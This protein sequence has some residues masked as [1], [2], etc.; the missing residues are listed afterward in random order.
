MDAPLLINI[1][2]ILIIF[3][4]GAIIVYLRFKDK[5]VVEKLDEF[6]E[7]KFELP[8]IIT[9]IKDTINEITNSNLYDLGLNEEEFKR[10]ANKRSKLKHALKESAHGD[11]RQKKYVKSYLYDLLL[12]D[13]G[14]N[15]E[16]INLT[17]PFDDTNRLTSQDKFDILIKKVQKKHKYNALNYLIEKHDLARLKNIIEGGETHS[18]IIT[19]EEIDNVY[20]KEV[21][22][23][24]FEDKL[25][26]IVQRVYQQYKGFGVIDE[27]RDMNI[28]GV[29]GG[30]NGLPSSSVLFGE[31]GDIYTEQMAGVTMPYD[32]DSVWIFYKGKSI[33]LSFLSFGSEL[34]LKRVCHNIYKYNMPG[35]LTENNGFKV[36]EMKDGSRVVVV[37]PSFAESYAFFV[38][39]FDIPNAN[40]DSL[41]PE[42]KVGN[43]AM[44]KLA[45]IF[46]M[47]G[48]RVTAITGA[49]GSGKTT[50]MMAMVKHISATLNVRVQEMAF[51]LHLRKIFPWRNILSF[52]ETETVTGQQGLDL[53][54]KVDGSVTL[55]GEMAEMKTAS[56]VIQ[57][58]EVA[59]DFTMFTGH[60]NTPTALVNYMSNALVK[61]DGFSNDKAEE[62]VVNVLDFNIHLR[63]KQNG[64]RH[65]ERITEVIPLTEKKEYPELNLENESFPGMFKEF[66]TTFRDFAARTTDRK[67]Y[68]FRDIIK[69]QDGK[70]VWV[71]SITERNVN[72]MKEQM[73]EDEATAFDLFMSI[74]ES[75]HE[76]DW[77]EVI[78]KESPLNLLLNKEVIKGEE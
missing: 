54:K 76:D 48:R 5:K 40:L 7:K 72:E 58:A 78:G 44:V 3:C 51:E 14:F 53:G 66:L 46:L 34:E 20:K 19:S 74:C 50:L 70:Y 61:V 35:P 59:S 71:N 25:W 45:L 62:Q 57:T 38:R 8:V 21:K 29:S 2:L 32:Y 47:K 41:F 15:D 6:D 37:R 22:S 36:N 77:D 10:R 63:R 73:T 4:V 43:S 11:I 18:Y 52:R 1:I 55:L 67:T 9:W 27:I 23:L 31:D 28:D 60:Q 33:H 64:F 12:Q 39:K 26:V 49:Q 68:E 56:Q 17:I 65:L 30:V 16:T 75:L 42:G 69:F 13:Y 24:T